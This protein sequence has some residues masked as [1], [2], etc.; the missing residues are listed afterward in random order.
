MGPSMFFFLLSF[1]AFVGL[2]VVYEDGRFLLA[3]GL[4]FL[5]IALLTGLFGI[6][7]V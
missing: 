5:V 6:L 4:G 7:G 2:A 1:I 3:T